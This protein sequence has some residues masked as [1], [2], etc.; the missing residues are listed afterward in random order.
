MSNTRRTKPDRLTHRPGTATKIIK[1]PVRVRRFSDKRRIRRP[2]PPIMCW[3]E[4]TGWCDVADLVW[5]E[6]RDQAAGT[7]WLRR[8]A[9]SRDGR[10]EA[11]DSS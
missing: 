11:G 10:N 4:G 5:F 8:G 6:L 1:E 9:P 3:P 7:R 2:H